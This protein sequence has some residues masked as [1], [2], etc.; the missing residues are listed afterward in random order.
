M[1]S[2][3][4]LLWCFL[5]PPCGFC[6]SIRICFLRFSLC[7]YVFR[8]MC[9]CPTCKPILSYSQ[10]F[11]TDDTH[12]GR[13]WTLL[14]LVLMVAGVSL[15]AFP[16]ISLQDFCLFVFFAMLYSHPIT[17]STVSLLSVSGVRYCK[18]IWVCAWV[19]VHPKMF[20]ECVLYPWRFK[21][22][23]SRHGPTTEVGFIQ[24]CVQK[25]RLQ[26]QILQRLNPQWVSQRRRGRRE[27]LRT[28]RTRIKMQEQRRGAGGTEEGLRKVGRL[29]QNQRKWL[30]ESKLDYMLCMD[31]L[32][33]GAVNARQQH[34]HAVTAPAGQSPVTYERF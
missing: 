10:L 1:Y 23:G 13:R 25:R 22:L 9:I 11:L 29:G 14:W 8:C 6:L 18:I 33:R 4:V 27:R 26:H 16:F 7:A 30:D 20:I 15:T 5:C 24:V 17:P 31:L 12:L 28:E 32:I 3:R 2:M 21:P 19:G 34:Y